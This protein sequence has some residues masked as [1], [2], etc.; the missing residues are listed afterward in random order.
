MDAQQPPGVVGETVDMRLGIEGDAGLAREPLGL[1]VELHQAVV[2][3]L[4]KHAPDLHVERG[5]GAAGERGLQIALQG[6]QRVLL[7]AFALAADDIEV[8]E[9]A[10]GHAAVLRDPRLLGIACTLEE[11]DARQGIDLRQLISQGLEPAGEALALADA[12]IPTQIPAEAELEVGAGAHAPT[13][14]R[15]TRGFS[16]SSSRLSPMASCC[17]RFSGMMLVWPL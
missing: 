9:L 12:E 3:R 2:V 11:V 16:A 14:W 17:T 4:I 7:A 6:R 10:V 15:E 1:V 8:G 5:H 13:A